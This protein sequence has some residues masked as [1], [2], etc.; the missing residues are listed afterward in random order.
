MKNINGFTLLELLI[1]MAVLVALVTAIIISI[2][3]KKRI[4]GANDTRIKNNIGQI[5]TALESYYTLKNGLYP[6][7]LSDLVEEQALKTILTPPDGG[8]Y[9]SGYSVSASCEPKSCEAALFYPLQDP[10]VS[11]SVWCWRSAIGQA[12]ETT[13]TAC[14]P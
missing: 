14:T 1:A 10:Q 5:S 3:P 9:S 11:G 2:N 6:P 12:A 7:S 8:S 4:S 13:S